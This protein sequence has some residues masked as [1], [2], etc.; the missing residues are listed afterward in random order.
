[1]KTLVKIAIAGIAVYTIGLVVSY[2]LT[3]IL[4]LFST[5][6]AELTALVQ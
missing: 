1:M 2:T 3:V 5:I 4:P 6:A